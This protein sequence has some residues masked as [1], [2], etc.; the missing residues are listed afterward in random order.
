[1]VGRLAS[2]RRWAT[3]TASAS[4]AAFSLLPAMGFKD[5]LDTLTFFLAGIVIDVGSGLS[6]RAGPSAWTAALLGAA[7]HAS[8]P[9]IRLLYLPLSGTPYPSLAAGIAYPIVLH[10]LFG[11]TGAVA[12]VLL[13]KL[14]RRQNRAS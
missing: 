5:P 6:N 2:Q 13:L 8:K 7:A 3:T 9:L 11:A 10:A 1:M 12:A 4:A 14:I